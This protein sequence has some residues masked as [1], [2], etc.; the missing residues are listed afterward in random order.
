MTVL[1]SHSGSEVQSGQKVN[2]HIPSESI[3]FP[4]FKLRFC[5]HLHL[6]I[7]MHL[8]DGWHCVR[9]VTLTIPM[10]SIG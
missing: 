1:R 10:D 8:T 4:Q 7:R 6:K 2:V 3:I 9:R 5:S